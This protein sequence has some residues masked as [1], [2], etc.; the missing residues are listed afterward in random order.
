[1]HPPPCFRHPLP[2]DGIVVL[3]VASVIL[4]VASVAVP[5][6]H[7]RHRITPK[8]ILFIISLCCCNFHV[9]AITCIVHTTPIIVVLLLAVASVVVIV[10]TGTVLCICVCCPTIIAGVNIPIHAQHQIVVIIICQILIFHQKLSHSWLLGHL[11]SNT[12]APE[13]RSYI[14]Y[15]SLNILSIYVRFSSHFF[16]NPKH[17]GLTV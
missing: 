9:V 2:L 7:L 10:V 5:C 1:M 13:I 3:V 16:S 12:Y 17:F 15:R 4:V 8:L 11:W 14:V 6:Y